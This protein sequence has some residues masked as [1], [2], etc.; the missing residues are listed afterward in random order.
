MVF[1]FFILGQTT[2]AL[3]V[4]TQQIAQNTRETEQKPQ[5][6]LNRTEKM[7]QTLRKTNKNNNS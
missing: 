1:Q 4:Q 2:V 6:K 7:L 3:R 5:L